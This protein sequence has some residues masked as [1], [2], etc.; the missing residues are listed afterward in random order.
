MFITELRHLAAGTGEWRRMCA[1]RIHASAAIARW[2]MT[3]VAVALLLPLLR[4][5]PSV[6]TEGA[7]TTRKVTPLCS[8][9][10]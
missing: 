3:P 6:L 2:A 4:A 1:R 5:F 7:R 10:F 8:L 9:S